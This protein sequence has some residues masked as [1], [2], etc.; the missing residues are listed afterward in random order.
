MFRILC[1]I[2]LFVFSGF[3][4]GNQESLI[5][6]GR[7]REGIKGENP[8][9]V[10]FSCG[11]PDDS[12]ISIQGDAILSPASRFSCQSQGHPEFRH[13]NSCPAVLFQLQ[14]FLLDLPPP[15][16]II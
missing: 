2:G 12:E 6:S 4:A 11:L 14:P 1:I 10:F 13:S 16:A 8:V 7:I 3:S 15:D 9:P 5:H